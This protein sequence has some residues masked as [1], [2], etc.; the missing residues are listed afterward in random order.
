VR[1]DSGLRVDSLRVWLLTGPSW[2]QAR[3]EITARLVRDDHGATATLHAADLQPGLTTVQAVA[4]RRWNRGHD[5]DQGASTF[6]WEPAVDLSTANRCDVTVAIEC[7]MPFPNDFYT[8]ADR[9]TPTGRRVHIDPASMNANASGVR[10]NPAEWN[11]N[12]GFSPGSMILSYVA[13]LDLARTGAA[14][15]TDIGASPR[16][17]RSCCSTPRPGSAGRSSP[18]STP[19]ARPPTRIRSSSG[20]PR[21]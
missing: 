2:H 7:L 12:D 11:R 13:G 20:R 3:H 15:I 8:V 10:V 19:K 16:T 18:S 17:S 6:S 14:P 21:T 9:T 4:T 5:T 1:L